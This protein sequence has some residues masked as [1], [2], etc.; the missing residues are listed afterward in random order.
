MSCHNAYPDHVKG[1]NEEF[2]SVPN[3]I[4]CERCHGPGEL[5]VK[6]KMSGNIIDTSK[7][8]D[9]TIVNPS[10]LKKELQFDICRRCHLQGTSVLKNKKDWNDFIPGTI[11]SETLVTYLPRYENDETF[12]MASHVDRLQ[13]SDV[14]LKEMSPVLVVIIL[15][16]A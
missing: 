6:E 14:I 1:S 5:H 3:G 15:I 4:D 8:I 16:K 7:Y 2:R 10:K 11:L 13:Q 9:Y 12:I